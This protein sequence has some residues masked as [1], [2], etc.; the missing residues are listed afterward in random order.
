MKTKKI[1]WSRWLFTGL[2]V[3][4]S[5]AG[6]GLIWIGDFLSGICLI[7]SAFAMEAYT[8]LNRKGVIAFS[9]YILSLGLLVLTMVFAWSN[10]Q[11]SA[12]WFRILMVSTGLVQPINE[13]YGVDL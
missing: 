13:L 4:A 1:Y 7:Y 8:F 11:D 3:F 5:S 2:F 6:I 10:F 12:G 9:P